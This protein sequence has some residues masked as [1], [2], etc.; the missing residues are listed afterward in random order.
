MLVVQDT[1]TLNLTGLHSIPELGPIDSGGLARGVHVQT[2][3][4][5]T[6]TG[7]VIGILH[8]QYWA[9]PLPGQPGPQAKESAQGIDGLDGA[10][11]ALYTAAGER[12][13][14][15]LIQVMDREGDG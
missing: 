7:Q 8:Q 10:R 1:T 15:R 6:S 5:V 12:A 2:A 11:E 13:V 14:P 9:R 4:A 3:L